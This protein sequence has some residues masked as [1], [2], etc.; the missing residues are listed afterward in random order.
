MAR[1]L[2]LDS[3]GGWRHLMNRGLEKRRIFPDERANEHFVKLLSTG[4]WLELSAR[5]G[6][7][8]L[9][10]AWYLARSDGGMRLAELGQAASYTHF[11][12]CS[13]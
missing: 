9:P 6:S 2:R 13:L 5:R 7:G 4:D 11:E 10:A 3:E 12:F 8:A 1:P